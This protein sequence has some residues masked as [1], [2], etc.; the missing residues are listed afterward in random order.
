VATDLIGH[1]RPFFA[2]IAA[3]VSPNGARRMRRA[4]ELVVGVSVGVGVGDLLIS[5]IGSGP[6][7]IGLVVALA[8]TTAV[9]LDGGSLIATQAGSSAVLVA[10]LLPPG[11]TGGL[12]RCL[13]ALVGGAIGILV[14]MLLPADPIAPVRSAV[15]TI[16]DELSASVRG[17]GTAISERI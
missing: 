7:Q 8:M 13:D 16:L 9:W 5:V 6:W 10:T 2:P 11:G 12:E 4:V 1:Q 14:V 15:I 3:V 17:V